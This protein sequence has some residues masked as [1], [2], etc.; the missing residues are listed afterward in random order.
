MPNNNHFEQISHYLQNISGNVF[1]QDKEHRYLGCNSNLV[2]LAHLTLSNVQTKN[3]IVGKTVHEILPEKYALDIFQTD[4]EVTQNA[5][6][7]IIEEK[8]IGSNGETV[9]FL[10]KK[11]PMYDIKREVIG[12]I[13]ISFDITN[14]Q[15]LTNQLS[16]INNLNK[17]I[18]N[19]T[20]EQ[21]KEKKYISFLDILKDSN[22]DR[23]YLIGNYE[24]IYLTKREAECV[25]Y[26]TQG[27]T[28]KQIGKKLTLSPRTVEAYLANIKAK[29]KC[30]TI[31][32]LVSKIIPCLNK[33]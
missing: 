22:I 28:A 20:L 27:N 33:I 14:Y 23:F 9:Y 8:G 18:L 6:E 3:D 12:L 2:D 13:G 32:E 29:L 17:E 21:K 5:V 4:E 16:K 15:K 1:W 30:H 19:K 11:M 25:F 10:S 24:N 31:T 7:K 26:L